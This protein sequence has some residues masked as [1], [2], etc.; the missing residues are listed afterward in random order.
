MKALL[1]VRQMSRMCQMKKCL[2]SAK[3]T[4][5][6]FLPIV[7]TLV[8]SQSTHNSKRLSTTWEIARIGFCQN[9]ISIFSEQQPQRPPLTLLGMS[10]HMLLQ[11]SRLRKV[12]LAQIALK[13][14]MS[15]VTLQMPVDF[16]LAREAPLF[17][18]ITSLPE[19]VV[20]RLAT[21]NVLPV[22]VPCKVF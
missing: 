21:T 9:N 14:T 13:W 5:E 8:D 6:G 15:R 2:P 18:P 22:E 1:N 3:G 16:L 7:R 10:P 12:L 19:A 4:L 17:R 20:P 11:S